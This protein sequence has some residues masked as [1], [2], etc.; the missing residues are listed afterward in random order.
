MGIVISISGILVTAIP[1]GISWCRKRSQFLVAI[2]E[3]IK[4]IQEGQPVAVT[5]LHDFSEHARLYNRLRPFLYL[6]FK[7]KSADAAFAEYR[8]WHDDARNA[9]KYPTALFAQNTQEEV[10]M[11]LSHLNN[12]KQSI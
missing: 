1:V 4:H 7:T 10:A 3:T 5:I 9:G 8:A 11:I 12:L 6:A 2:S